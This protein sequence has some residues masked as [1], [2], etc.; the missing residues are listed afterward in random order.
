MNLKKTS[1]LVLVVFLISAIVLGQTASI[2]KATEKEIIKK[3][4]SK[5]EANKAIVVKWFSS[6]WGKTCD[7]K[8]CR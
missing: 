5:E 1:M 3:E 7:L 8:I 6:F 4:L 2:Q